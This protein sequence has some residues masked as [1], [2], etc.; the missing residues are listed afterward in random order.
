MWAIPYTF[1][2]MNR[3]EARSRLGSFGRVDQL[4]TS[5]IHSERFLFPS[6]DAQVSPRN[7]NPERF[8]FPSPQNVTLPHISESNT[9]SS[10]HHSSGVFVPTSPLARSLP[11]SP[12]LRTPPRHSKL[13][14]S[15]STPRSIN[16][17]T[18]VLQQGYSQSWDAVKSESPSN[19]VKLRTHCP[20]YRLQEHRCSLPENHLTSLNIRRG[21]MRKDF[22]QTHL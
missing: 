5:S 10:S 6:G 9:P 14:P 12:C 13:K 8:L 16:P 7:T 2:S 19:P 3:V 21:S 11:Q 1:Y 17:R 20:Q 15:Q 4:S 22:K 18:S